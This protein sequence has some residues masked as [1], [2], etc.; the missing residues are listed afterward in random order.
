M[1]GSAWHTLGQL[2]APWCNYKLL[3]VVEKPCWGIGAFS[4]LSLI[5]KADGI[6]GIYFTTSE[7]SDVKKQYS[8]CTLRP[9]I[10]SL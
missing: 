1:R 3:I 9:I 6:H 5:E 2:G 10:D 4:L 8:V 7:K